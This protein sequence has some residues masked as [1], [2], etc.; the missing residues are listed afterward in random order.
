MRLCALLGIPSRRLLGHVLT[1]PDYQD[2]LDLYHVDPWDEDRADLR[3]G[4]L[5]SAVLAPWTKKPPRPDKFML[6]AKQKEK[7]KQ[8][9]EQQKAIFRQA[10]RGFAKAG[11]QMKSK[12]KK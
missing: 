12:D 7:P 1:Q 3:N 9:E 11:Q 2:W 10:M 6:Y 5:I 4:Q 8:T